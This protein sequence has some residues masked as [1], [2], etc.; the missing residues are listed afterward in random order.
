MKTYGFSFQR[1]INFFTAL[2]NYIRWTWR[3]GCFGFRSRLQKPDML[4][5]PKAICIGSKVYIR[6]SARLEAVGPW[7]GKIPKI[8]IGNHTIIHPYFHCGAAESVKIGN[9]VL[10]AS[11][12]YITDHDHV[13]DDP[14]KPARWS[15]RLLTKPVI[16]E[17][18]VWLGEGAIILKG[19]TVGER[20]VVGAN[21]VVTKDVPAYTVVG[22]NPARVIKN[23]ECDGNR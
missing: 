3:F 11:R 7:V 16:I 8:T 13:F 9:N 19:V 22:G 2:L 18:G 5:K 4:T 12:V 14:A 10:I 15:G 1:T 20:A 17:D 6:K 21:A 23:I